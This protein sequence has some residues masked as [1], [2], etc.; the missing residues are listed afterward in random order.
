MSTT[1]TT[2]TL[3]YNPYDVSFDGYQNMYVVDT[4]NHRIQFFPQGF[5]Q[6]YFLSIIII[7]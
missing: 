2:G 5:K 4:Y 1:G 6:N 3:L 7:N